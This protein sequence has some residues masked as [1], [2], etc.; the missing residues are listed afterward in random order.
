MLSNL[1][2]AMRARRLEWGAKDMNPCALEHGQGIII[3]LGI[4]ELFATR[5][6]HCMLGTGFT[7]YNHW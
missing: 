2:Y 3:Y 1:M 4:E 5:I 6:G 7:L